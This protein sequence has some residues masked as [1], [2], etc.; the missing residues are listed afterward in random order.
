MLKNYSK[1]LINLSSDKD[2]KDRVMDKRI[3]ENLAKHEA[4]F[5]GVLE[6][7]KTSSS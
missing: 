5:E 4:Y 3:E 7:P 6:N 1:K 2:Y